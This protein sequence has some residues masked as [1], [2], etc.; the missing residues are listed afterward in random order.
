MMFAKRIPEI[1]NTKPNIPMISP[2]RVQ[3]SKYPRFLREM[4]PT[5]IEARLS[6]RANQGI[7]RKTRDST[8]IIREMID[9]VRLFS[10]LG[11]TALKA[12]SFSSPTSLLVFWSS[13]YWLFIPSHPFLIYSNTLLIN[14]Q[15]FIKKSWIFWYQNIFLTLWIKGRKAENNVNKA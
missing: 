2:A 14:N 1:E 6:T 5:I 9:R 7:K 8:A 15:C 10:F 11:I 13:L 4:L 12:Y 3:W